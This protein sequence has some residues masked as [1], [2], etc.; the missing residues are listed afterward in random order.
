MVRSIP[1]RAGEPSETDDG[2]VSPAVYPRACGGTLRN[3]EYS[4][5]QYGLSPRVRGNPS[6]SR[7]PTTPHRSIPARAGE[8]S[9][10]DTL[11]KCFEVYPRACGGT[12]SGAKPEGF[13]DG[14][15]PR[16]RG[17]RF[18]CPAIR[19]PGRSIPARAGE[20]RPCP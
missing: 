9:E 11:G 18:S 7:L 20:P 8:P 12:D 14:L 6:M 4:T 19:V 5:A 16:V 17:N 2:I 3:M 15:S 13:Y 1:A 10:I